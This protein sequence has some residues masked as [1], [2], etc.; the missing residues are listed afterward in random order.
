MILI[1]LQSHSNYCAKY[2]NAENEERYYRNR[3]VKGKYWRAWHDTMLLFLP[4]QVHIRACPNTLTTPKIIVIIYILSNC[5]IFRCSADNQISQFHHIE[6]AAKCA[7]LLNLKRFCLFLE[8]VYVV[9]C[10]LI[11]MNI[12]RLKTKLHKM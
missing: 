12:F 9:L 1:H 10:C 6:M 3:Y 5:D 11:Q 4:K 7:R 8:Y 2:R